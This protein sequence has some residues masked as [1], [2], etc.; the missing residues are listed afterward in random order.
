MLLALLLTMSLAANLIL[1]TSRDGQSVILLPAQV[2]GNYTITATH[3]DERYLA[4]AA[5]T[6]AQLYLS[7]TPS[8]VDFRKGNLEMGHPGSTQKIAV[9]LE[10]EAERIKSQ[11][12]TTSFSVRLSLTTTAGQQSQEQ[13]GSLRIVVSAKRMLPSTL[14]GYG[15]KRHSINQI[16]WVEGNRK[17]KNATSLNLGHQHKPRI[18]GRSSS[19][20]RC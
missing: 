2:S 1:L 16:T 11:R 10:K 3:F 15:I 14:H 7:A 8:T 12:L 20:P 5:T 9:D 17:M 4:D 19:N 18:T 6:V 13:L